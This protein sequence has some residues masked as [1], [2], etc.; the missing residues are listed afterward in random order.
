[1]FSRA[2]PKDFVARG[3][4][5]AGKCAVDEKVRRHV[6]ARSL[7]VAEGKQQ[8]SCSAK[9]PRLLLYHE[10]VVIG[11]AGVPRFVLP[12]GESAKGF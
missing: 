6:C 2:D 11:S 5:S 1:M 12:A 10:D 9:N 7:G 3:D 4:K 8:S